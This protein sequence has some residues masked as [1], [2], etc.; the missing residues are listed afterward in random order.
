MSLN[1]FTYIRQLIEE[2]GEA[3]T[4]LRTA[5]WGG[6][7]NIKAQSQLESRKAYVTARIDKVQRYLSML[8]KEVEDMQ[9]HAEQD[10]DLQ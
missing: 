1:E 5:Q 4:T 7:P 8:R 9:M 3:T 6:V 2:I 10:K